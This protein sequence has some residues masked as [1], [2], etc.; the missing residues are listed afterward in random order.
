MIEGHREKLL[1][2]ALADTFPASDPV[3]VAQPGGGP[4]SA[5]PH[6]GAYPQPEKDIAVVLAG[7]PRS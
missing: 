6:P 3:S 7:K 4:Q 5:A 2:Q 1:D